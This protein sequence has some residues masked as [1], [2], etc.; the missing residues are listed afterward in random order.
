M[1]KTIILF[2]TLVF[3][4][5]LFGQD[6]LIEITS[7]SGFSSFNVLYPTYFDPTNISSQPDLFAINLRNLTDSDL[8]FKLIV[9]LEWRGRYLVTNNVITPIN[10]NNY[11]IPPNA[12]MRVTNRD[13]ITD[14]SEYFQAE[15]D[16]NDILND[17]SDF[18]DLVFDMGRFPDGVYTFT[19]QAV[20]QDGSTP[21][22]NQE[23]FTINLRS[24]NPIT[25]I[26]PG[27]PIGFGVSKVM[28]N[29]P[30]FVW[31]SN[32]SQYTLKVWELQH[33]NYSVQQIEGLTPYFE[34]EED[35]TT[36]SFSLPVEYALENNRI[37]A[38]QV[39]GLV[40]TPAN[41]NPVYEKS[42]IYLFEVSN[43]LSDQSDN[44][45]LIQLIN[46]FSLDDVSGIDE[47]IKL[48]ENGYEL[49][50]ADYQRLMQLFSDGKKVKSIK[51]D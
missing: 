27:S 49:T 51:I 37:Y 45:L 30:Y 22:S 42:N 19:F 3:I 44:Q 28:D 9:S 2:I 26:T 4:F 25:L 10:A 18:K 7:E 31:F 24:P 8:Q 33:T 43:D 13:L 1:K 21:I 38:W 14:N 5:Q 41:T 39:V 48:L 40:E 6:N 23:T 29:Q 20:E 32:L 15:Q 17:N 12:V 36:T 50:E 11:P 34:N 16:W 46:Q 47:L 35:L